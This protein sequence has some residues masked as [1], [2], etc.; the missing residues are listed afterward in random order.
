MS[1]GTPARRLRCPGGH[2]R[3]LGL[4]GPG[5]GQ[6][7]GAA[8]EPSPSHGRAAPQL[9]LGAPG[10]AGRAG[11]APA[12]RPLPVSA[13]PGRAAPRVANGARAPA[14]RQLPRPHPSQA[15]HPGL[16]PARPGAD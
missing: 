2:R 4:T 6:V 7:A 8:R 9:L 11:A 15:A 10:P 14:Q 13:G 16:L 5:E 3:W 12:P 1:P